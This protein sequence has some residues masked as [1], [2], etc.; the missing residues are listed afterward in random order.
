[1]TTTNDIYIRNLRKQAEE[2][3]D[4]IRDDKTALK[5]LPRKI[6]IKERQLEIIRHTIR[7]LRAQK[8]K[9]EKK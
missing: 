1:M 9:T 2:L 6:Q 8:S 5:V 4:D 7:T 3:E